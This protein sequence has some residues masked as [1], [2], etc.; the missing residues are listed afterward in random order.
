[1]SSQVAIIEAPSNL[2]LRPPRETAVPGCYK[3]PWALRNAG[4]FEALNAIDL[5]CVIPPAYSGH[6]HPGERT[7]N[8]EAIAKYSH[9]LAEKIKSCNNAGAF[10]LVIGGDC[11]IL[12]GI[13]LHLKQIGK[14]GLLFLDGHSDF[15]HFGNSGKVDAAAGE[16]LALSIGLGDQNLTNLSG[17]GPNFDERKIAVLGVRD[18]D[19]HLEELKERSI[20]CSTST[21][22]KSSFR[23]SV[24]T[25]INV[26]TN[27]TEGFWIHLDLDV[28]DS[29]EMFAVDCPETDGISFDELSLLLSM[30]VNTQKCV[31]MNVTI[32]DP[33][34]DPEQQLAPSIVKLLKNTFKS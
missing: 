1:M 12:L 18:Y 23:D 2:G 34:L 29:S 22:L 9:L 4:L 27:Q 10:P 21:Q 25:A 6:W 24:N 30:A 31:G 5:G 17:S 15:R 3:M 19:E 14:H 26:V 7:R 28:V 16:D 11:S 8:S 13:G 32:Y 33:D 20:L